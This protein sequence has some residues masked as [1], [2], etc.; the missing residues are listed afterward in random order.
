MTFQFQ[1][2]FFQIRKNGLFQVFK[3]PAVDWCKFNKGDIQL[4]SFQKVFINAFRK[5]AP[6]LFHQCPFEGRHVFK[7]VTANKS[8]VNMIPLGSYKIVINGIDKDNCSIMTV[9]STYKIF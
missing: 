2:D 6:M 9:S 4:V 3:S 1:F 5:T 7:N 8:V